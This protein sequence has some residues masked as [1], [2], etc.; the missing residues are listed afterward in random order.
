MSSE[1]VDFINQIFSVD[2][3][4]HIQVALYRGK[5]CNDCALDY[6]AAS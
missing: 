5:R 1:L 6:L 4:C 2:N 3:I